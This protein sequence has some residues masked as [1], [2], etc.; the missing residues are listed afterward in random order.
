MFRQLSRKLFPPDREDIM[1]WV[2]MGIGIWRDRV[3]SYGTLP[4][5]GYL[6]ID[7]E[8]T[9]ETVLD[10]ASEELRDKFGIPVRFQTIEQ[11]IES[12]K[13]EASKLGLR[14]YPPRC[15]HNTTR[16]RCS[17][18][19]APSI[20]ELEKGV[21]MVPVHSSGKLASIF[22]S[23]NKVHDG[24]HDGFFPYSPRP[25]CETVIRICNGDSDD[26]VLLYGGSRAVEAVVTYEGNKC[27]PL[28]FFIP[29]IFTFS[30]PSWNDR[31]ELSRAFDPL[32]QNACLRL[33][34]S[35]GRL[36]AINVGPAS[37][38]F[39][40]SSADRTEYPAGVRFIK[41]WETRTREKN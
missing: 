22:V 40:F 12:Q 34:D 39:K 3:S 21:A 2:E 26:D 20:Q 36:M 38:L 15:L 8:K 14:Y 6:K 33:H 31:G 16:V 11:F 29:T 32:C 18:T 1:A 25:I 19:R 9:N 41:Y 35:E 27:F 37:A 24:S 30:R 10:I 28:R 17:F 13:K 4:L 7:D 5:P 23:N